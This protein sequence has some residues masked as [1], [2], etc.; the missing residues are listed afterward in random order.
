MAK[1]IRVEMPDGSVWHVP[2]VEAAKHR[3]YHY[4]RKARDEGRVA[5]GNLFD[6][7]LAVRLEMREQ[8]DGLVLDWA[9]NNMDWS[10]LSALATRIRPPSAPDYA[11]WWP[12]AKSEVV[13]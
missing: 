12:N 8:D 3:A 1:V 2:F 5:A 13:S 9:R 11:A 7:E 6:F 10:Q 4:A